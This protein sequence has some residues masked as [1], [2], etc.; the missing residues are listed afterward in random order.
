MGLSEFPGFDDAM[1]L[2]LAAAVDR[3]TEEFDG[4]YDREAVRSLTEESACELSIGGIT[5]ESRVAAT[6]PS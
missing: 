5:I 1:R 6:P 3:L 4:L 2:R